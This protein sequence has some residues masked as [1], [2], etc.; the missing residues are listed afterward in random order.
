MTTVACCV[1]SIPPRRAMLA[2][3]LVS[4]ANQ[5]RPAD[6]IHVAVDHDRRGAAHTRNRTW[7]GARTDWI[8]FLDD[9]DEFHNNHLAACLWH[10]E[11]TG[12]DIV[13]P[14]FTVQGGSDPFPGQFGT[15]WDPDHPV[16]TT[17]VILIRRALL[18]DLDGYMEQPPES[19]GA[20]GMRA[21]EDF[22]LVR[23]ANAAG[24]K[25][26]HLPERTWTWNHHLGVAG[27]TS[28]LPNR[29]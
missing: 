15:P 25:I 29:W 23:R 12:A 9:D 7:R 20:D 5:T 8:A 13:Y 14:W 24:A 21:G 1:P 4:V 17:I 28:G 26:S 11:E 2:R 18:L 16:Q 22:D 10:A 3:A 6:E 27:N 19:I